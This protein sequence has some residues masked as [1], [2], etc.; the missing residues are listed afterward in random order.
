MPARFAFK[1]VAPFPTCHASTICEL[2]DGDL[3]A[4]WFA[5]SREGAPDSC[6]LGSRLPAGADDWQPYRVLV[7]A[8]GR[9]CGNPRLFLGPDAALWLLAPVNY[10]RW[11]RGGT[12]L[13]LKRSFDGGQTWT[14]LERFPMPAGVLGKNKPLRLASGVW[15]IPAEYENAWEITFIRSADQGRHWRRIDC[16]GRGAILDQPTVVQLAGGDLLA[17]M[18]SWEG[19]VYH[20][21][22]RDDGLT[23]DAPAPLPVHNNNSG[24]DLVRLRSGRLV[25]ACNPVGLGA[26]GDIVVDERLRAAGRSAAVLD[27]AGGAELQRVIDGNAPARRRTGVEALTAG[28]PAWGPRT[29]LSLVVSD[30]EGRSWRRAR[31]LETAPGE[32]SY[33]AIIQ[34]STGTLHVTYTHRRTAI[35]HV[36]LAEGEL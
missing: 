17:C 30:D 7:H 20:T 32:Y 22:S 5:G 11:C 15:I 10:G 24:L 33:P 34:A 1:G 21:R 9:A 6:I 27:S 36:C 29:P 26:A 2:P 14:D 28:Y 3:L 4:A 25:L 12:R 13:H 35:R 19:W 31:D 16:P 18:R 8:A 23:W